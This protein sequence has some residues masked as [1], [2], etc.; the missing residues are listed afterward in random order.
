M[1]KNV[2]LRNGVMIYGFP[3]GKGFTY[4]CSDNIIYLS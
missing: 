4:L 2:P 3:N 1:E